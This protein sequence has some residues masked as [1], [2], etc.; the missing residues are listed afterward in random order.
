MGTKVISERV[1]TP[2]LSD[3]ALK[4]E[5]TALEQQINSNDVDISA[6]NNTINSLP[7]NMV[8][9]YTGGLSGHTNLATYS[10]NLDAIMGITDKEKWKF[11]MFTSMS[12]VYKAASGYSVDPHSGWSTYVHSYTSGAVGYVNIGGQTGGYGKMAVYARWQ[13]QA[14]AIRTRF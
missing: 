2:D 5:V 9:V 1:E 8:R 11:Y 3:Y 13:I 10:Y 4:T 14:I 7:N 6:L 12:G